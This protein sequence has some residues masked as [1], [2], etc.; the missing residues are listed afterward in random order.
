MPT[1][2]NNNMT[3]NSDKQGE[4]FPRFIN[5]TPYGEDLFEGKSQDRVAANI[6]EIIINN[7]DCKVIGID[8]NWGIGKSNL[9][10]IIRKK[11]TTISQ[12]KYNFFIYDAWGHQEDLQ[13]RSFLEEITS[14]LTKRDT[15]QVSIIG[16]DNKWKKKLKELLAKSK[17]TEKKTIPSLSIGIVFSGLILIL[18]PFFKA[19]SDI[20]ECN[21]WKIL[22]AGIPLL[23]LVLLFLYY[24][25]F[26]TKQEWF[27]KRFSE[28]ISKLFYIY[29][30][31]QKEDVTFE[32][33]SEDEPSVRK[34]RDWMKEISDDLGNK[35]LIIV[36]DNMDRLPNDKVLE[37][38]SSI[39]TF[40]AENRYDNIK[41]VIPFDRKHIKD[42]FNK[43]N[44]GANY[45]DDF[46]NKTFNI[47]Y[48]VSPPILSDWKSFF[49]IKW[50][51]AFGDLGDEFLQIIQVFDHLCDSKTPREILAFINEFVATSQIS[52]D[53]QYRYIALFLSSKKIILENPDNEIIRPSYLKSLHFLYGNDEDLPK[54]MASLVYQINP[55]RAIEVIFSEKLINALNNNNSYQIKVISESIFFKDIL[56]KAITEVANYGNTILGLKQI[57]NKVPQK[58][59]NDL[60]ERLDLLYKEFSTAIVQDYQ[61]IILDKI[62]KKREFL[63]NNLQR[64]RDAVSF[65][66][67]DYYNSIIE[68]EKYLKDKAPDILIKD[69]LKSKKT[70]AEDFINLLKKTENSNTFLISCDS[71]E[72]N[73]LLDTIDD[74]NELDNSAWMSHIPTSYDLFKYKSSLENKIKLN[75]T[76]RAKVAAYYKAYKNVSKINVKVLL[77]DANI[78][79]HFINSADPKDNFYYD[80]ISM[81][82]SKADSFQSYAPYFEEVL[83][84]T[85]EQTV[86]GLAGSIQY[87]SDYDD[88]LIKLLEFNKP[89]LKAVAKFLT[90]NRHGALRVSIV[91]ILKRIDEILNV[92]GINPE[93]FII[94][95]NRWSANVITDKNILDIL[96]NVT[97]FKLCE[98]ISTP[99]TN[100]C[101]E[102]ANEYYETLSD[103][104]WSEEFQNPNSFIVNT[105][106][107]ILKN[108]YS[109]KAVSAIKETLLKVAKA[110]I[111]IP[112]L[113]IWNKII[114]K[115]NKSSIRS[116][117]KDVRNLFINTKEID[118]NMF[119]FFGEMLFNYGEMEKDPGSLRRIFRKQIFENEY[120]VNI[121]LNHKDNMIAV[122]QNGEEKEDFDNEI[123]V[124]VSENRPIVKKVADILNIETQLE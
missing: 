79:T 16:D 90:E 117:M 28:A 49:E 80:L 3:D 96:K 8:G 109:T 116:T 85:D 91:T 69:F 121:I 31:S 120:C 1:T 22:I 25:F 71:T 32:R 68:I 26:E 40:F 23:L 46:I 67:I 93:A 64:F 66:A 41:V 13:R 39:H 7:N 100:R 107:G 37:L 114:E 34:F 51:E 81:R 15:D 63:T 43:A 56:P 94:K 102:V 62:Q 98:T 78:Y 12:G 74:L 29:Q 2:I 35:K 60:Y 61:I 111:N 83:A 17:E 42:A 27:N 97:F 110:E 87:F 86:S 9:I 95:L 112:D 38:W 20:M 57:E 77:Q 52:T 106:I 103:D 124:L 118:A 84:K 53:I 4:K 89:L 123:K 105:S 104:Q 44:G 122:Y 54:Y 11:L 18:T 101:I 58:S 30:K 47:V 75:E 59:W 19:I 119:L 36:F 50:K 88:L 33:I 14:F 92:T 72:L 108:Q 24:L 5:N 45:T 82:I 10:E 70:T 73:N 55:E 76:D 113:N 65:T 99:L 21:T 6:S 115:S 48:R